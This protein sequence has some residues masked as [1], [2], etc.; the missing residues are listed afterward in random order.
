MRTSAPGNCV[1]KLFAKATAASG[2]ASHTTKDV[3]PLPASTLLV[4]LLLFS[5]SE[6]DPDAARCCRC[7][8]NRLN[9]ISDPI[10][11]R[12]RKL[13]LCARR[14]AETRADRSR[15][16]RQTAEKRILGKSGIPAGVWVGVI[17]RGLLGARSGHSAC[18]SCKFVTLDRMDGS[19]ACCVVVVLVFLR[20]LL[21]DFCSL[22]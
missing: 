4:S 22:A 20:A 8:A 18:E 12:P 6:P 15:A 2:T 16:C 17:A 19:R 5:A 3:V 1:R 21:F 13:M 14:E 11:P 7:F 9:A 10:R